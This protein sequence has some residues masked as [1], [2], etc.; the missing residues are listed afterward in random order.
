MRGENENKK[1]ETQKIRFKHIQQINLL[2]QSIHFIH[3]FFIEI[4]CQI[5]YIC[6][7]F[8][9]YCLRIRESDKNKIK[10]TK[11]K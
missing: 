10:I 5:T 11:K 2:H 6:F 1:N 8:S 4:G 3:I 9:I 7:D